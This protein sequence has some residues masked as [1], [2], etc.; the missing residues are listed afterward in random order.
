MSYVFNPF[1]G[2]LD[3]TAAGGGEETD[4]VFSVSAAA[5]IDAADITNWDGKQAALTF[6]LS[7]TLGGTG[8]NNGT[9][10]LTV[11]ATGTAALLARDQIFTGINS[12]TRGT[13]PTNTFFGGAGNTTGTGG[14]N[15]GLGTFS[16][17]DF[18]SGYF[19]FG[20]GYFTLRK[21]TTGYNNV[22]IGSESLSNVT[23]AIWNVAIGASAGDTTTGSTNTYIGF[24]AAAG[25]TSGNNNVV[26]GAAAG[27]SSGAYSGCVLIGYLAGLTN[28]SSNKL[29]INN[30]ESSTPLIYGDFAAGFLQTNHKT[31]T[32]NAVKEGLRLQALVSTA[33]T[34]SAAGFGIGQS[35]FAETATDATYQQQGLISTSWID[36]TNA[37]RK[38]KMSLSAYD[39][40]ARLGLE[41]E[42][43]GTAPMLGFYGVAPVIRA[44]NAGAAGAF[45]ANTSGI[46]ND[47]ATF[48]GYTLGQI[49]Q[50]LINIGIL[51]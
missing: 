6:P 1:T 17:G 37:S 8:V 44:T 9:N 14:G 26:I 31:T 25:Q 16:L 23:T 39:T 50:A 3:W 30:D 4:P 47:T 18:T 32:T 5:G 29:Y 13:D 10:A 15:V 28:A 33:S 19:N 45:V 35:F 20:M 38:A 21:L 51:T 2:N 48:G 46:A 49:A 40:A 27:A 24:R 22:A 41:I 11:P 42:A 36:A 7:P 12:F 43:S 34:G